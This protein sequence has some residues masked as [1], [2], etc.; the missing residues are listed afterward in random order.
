MSLRRNNVFFIPGIIFLVSFYSCS[1]IFVTDISDKKMTIISPTDSMHSQNSTQIFWW[2]PVPDADAY[3]VQIVSP[4]F[5]SVEKIM[6]DTT[7]TTNK[8]EL[9]FTPG[10]YEWRICAF[11]SASITPYNYQSFQIDSAS[12]KK[13]M[14][15]QFILPINW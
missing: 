2:E 10:A 9:D 6:Y 5:S 12:M 14:N 1:D 3:S 15:G 4:F 8:I 11:N 7:L 13:K